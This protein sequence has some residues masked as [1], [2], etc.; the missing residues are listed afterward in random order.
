MARMFK[1]INIFIVLI[2]VVAAGYLTVKLFA[3][4]AIVYMGQPKVGP[5]LD[6]DGA[7]RLIANDFGGVANIPSVITPIHARAYS[8][9]DGSL[10]WAIFHVPRGQTDVIKQQIIDHY[11]HQPAE[12]QITIN[13]MSIGPNGRS[14]SIPLDN[15]A[16]T[17][18][19]LQE[20]PQADVVSISRPGSQILWTFSRD[21]EWIFFRRQQ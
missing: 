21:Q 8:S 5:E 11:Q 1:K 7:L 12:M 19:N 17:W 15:P 4:A 9:W 18:W 10:T 20:V 16:P 3:F 13:N 2:F 6:R 14:P